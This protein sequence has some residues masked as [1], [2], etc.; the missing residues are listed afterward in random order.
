MRR[1]GYIAAREFV[2]ATATRGFII[3]IL[4]MPAIMTLVF[5]LGPRL[6]NQRS[7]PVHGQIALVDPTGRVTSELRDTLAPAA[8]AARRADSARRAIAAAPAEVR[9]LASGAGARTSGVVENAIGLVPDL[10]IVERSADPNVAAALQSDKE[11]LTAASP[12]ARH[13][14]LVVIHPDAVSLATGRAA[15]GSYDLYVPSNLDDRI[16][17]VIHEGLREALINARARTQNLDPNSINAIVWVPRPPSVTVTKRDQRATASGFN[18]ALPIV[19]VVLLLFG[20]MMGGQGLV[21]ST[22]EEKSSRVVEVLLSAVS[23]LEL[24]AG[25]ILGQM[26]VSLAVLGLYIVLGLMLL[27]SFSLFGLL[28][29]SLVFY[30]VVFFVIS[31]LTMGSMMVAVGAAVNDMSE[32]QSLMM[33]V[34]FL[35]MAPAMLAAPIAREPNSMFSTVI[36]FI[37]PVNAFAMLVRL[38]SSA[39]PPAWQ[40]WLTIVIGMAAVAAAV[41]FAAKVFKMGLLL[42]GKPPDLATLIRWARAA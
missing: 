21:T 17:A 4:F 13:V 12:A 18:R 32:A 3:G 22:V 31:Y 29:V 28:D 6:M 37:P 27:V 30:L 19:M 2:A 11:W 34:V 38:T 39:P 15:Y 41:S 42:H 26:G 8:I 14:A 16:E 24:M 10:Q 25:K 7:A 20:V 23:P 36:S 40:A 35:M 1:V 33:P 9:D 5:T